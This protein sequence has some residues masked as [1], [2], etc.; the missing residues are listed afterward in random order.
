M[1]VG[2][3]GAQRPDVALQGG[4]QPGKAPRSYARGL[5]HIERSSADMCADFH[6]RVQGIAHVLAD[7]TVLSDEV[8][9]R[10]YQ[11]ARLAVARLLDKAEN[12][13][14]SLSAKLC[15][16]ACCDANTLM[17]FGRYVSTI[18]HLYRYCPVLVSAEHMQTEAN[19]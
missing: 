12:M 18:D 15:A 10:L 6:S 13:A 16:V 5:Q 8:G 17:E 9:R 3:C 14:N 2:A 7:T 11:P 4:M 1:L 19:A